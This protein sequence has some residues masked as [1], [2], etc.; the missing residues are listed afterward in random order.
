VEGTGVELEGVVELGPLIELREVE[1]A[2]LHLA[3]VT[4]AHLSGDDVDFA[5]LEVV[6]LYLGELPLPRIRFLD[7]SVEANLGGYRSDR[8]MA[9]AMSLALVET[10]FDG[11]GGVVQSVANP[12]LY[13]I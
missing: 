5:G 12:P 8:M 1:F 9:F 10:N 7:C 11:F 4:V 2:E 6:G 3:D 13:V